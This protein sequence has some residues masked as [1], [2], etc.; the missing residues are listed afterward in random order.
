MNSETAR[1][2]PSFTGD[3][4]P[5]ELGVTL[6]HE[7]L[8]VSDAEL[9]RNYPHPEWDETRL[10]AT[11]V[12]ELTALHRLGVDTVADLTVLGL[13]RNVELAR[14]VAEG[15]AAQCS[16]RLLAATGYYG[17]ETLPPFFR[18]NGPG[19]LIDRPDPLTE[20]FVTD[21]TEGIA[22]TG[23]RAALIKIA[24]DEAGI[25]PDIARVFRAAAAAQVATGVPILTHSHSPSRN[26]GDQQ[27]LLLELGVPLERVVIGHAGDSADL[28]YLMRLADRGST[29]GFDR[30]GMTHAASDE[31]RIDTLVALCDRGYSDRIAVSHDAAFFSRVTPPSWRASHAPD[32]RMSHFHTQIMPRLT[33][34]GVSAATLHELLVTNPRRILSGS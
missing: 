6:I 16:L 4:A 26:G 12:S 28:D 32:W 24:S 14:R 13:G 8:F 1:A 15:V 7:H 21:I 33:A 30:F 27:D 10:V 20:M 2:I 11:A 34:R 31:Q 18:I 25:T 29:L 9:D 5:A 3:V 23:I 17:A 22:G 19:R